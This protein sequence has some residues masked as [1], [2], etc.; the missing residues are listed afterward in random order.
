MTLLWRLLQDSWQPG[1]LR[2]Q[3]RSRNQKPAAP[4]GGSASLVRPQQGTHR[5]LQWASKDHWHNHRLSDVDPTLKMLLQSPGTVDCALIPAWLIPGYSLHHRPA[6]PSPAASIP[7]LRTGD[8]LV[9]TLF[10]PPSPSQN[11]HQTQYRWRGPYGTSL[12]SGLSP[13]RP[14]KDRRWTFLITG[15]RYQTRGDELKTHTLGWRQIKTSGKPATDTQET[16]GWFRSA[17]GGA[18]RG[19]LRWACG[20]EDSAWCWPR[21]PRDAE[22]EGTVRTHPG[23]KQGNTPRRELRVSIIFYNFTKDFHIYDLICVSEKPQR[24]ELFNWFFRWSW[25]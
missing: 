10:K 8:L 19:A 7:A 16:T 3:E 1:E 5:W 20:R 13:L 23:L 15:E 4:G 9:D 2:P 6:P 24:Q 12:V 18:G 11:P 17:C 22:R 21:L 25:V 14:R